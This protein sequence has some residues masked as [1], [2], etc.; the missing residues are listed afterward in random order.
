MSCDNWER[1]TIIIPKRQW[2]AFRKA[3]MKEHNALQAE[4]LELA[5]ECYAR[6]VEV[7]KG[8]RGA[9]RRR[10]MN[11]EGGSKYDSVF[12]I[13]CPQFFDS[14]DGGKICRPK[15][16]SVDTRPISR[17]GRLHGPDWSVFF[18]DE[19]HSVEWQ[20]YRNNRAVE[21]AHEDP[22]VVKLFA[23]MR[24][25]QYTSG[26][27]GVIEGN[28]EYNAEEGCGTFYVNHTFPVPKRAPMRTRSPWGRW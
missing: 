23:A 14:D 21:H 11:F 27:G 13:V 20:V 8:L 19:T 17:G 1:G 25:I 3:M 16:K 9:M 6:I 28:D 5:M 7:C 22:F 2:A 24:R 4:R 15:K 18:N 26:T 10:A 12:N